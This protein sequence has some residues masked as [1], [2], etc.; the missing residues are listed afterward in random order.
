[1]TEILRHRVNGW[2][3]PPCDPTALVDAI[4]TLRAA[5]ELA[6]RVARV[7]LDD[8]ANRFSVGN[9]LEQMKRSIAG[10]QSLFTPQR[11]NTP[12][13]CVRGNSRGANTRLP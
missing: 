2:L 5:P 6:D 10:A 1:M 4:E 12:G 13:L 7:A 9:Y 3:I 8:A 11:G